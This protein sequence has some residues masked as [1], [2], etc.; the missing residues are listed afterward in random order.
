[1]K[2]EA[3]QQKLQF[4]YAELKDIEEVYSPQRKEYLLEEID[5]YELQLLKEKTQKHYKETDK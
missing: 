3:I 2:P 5:Y 1:M 4:L